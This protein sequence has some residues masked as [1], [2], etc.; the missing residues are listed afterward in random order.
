[1]STDMA[2][3]G[4]RYF[5]YVLELWVLVYIVWRGQ[6]RRLIGPW[7][8]VCLLFSVSVIRTWVLSICGL[9]SSEYYHAYWWTDLSLTLAAFL[10]VCSFFRRA[11]IHQER[12]WAILRLGLVFLFLLLGGV[13]ALWASVHCTRLFPFFIIEFSDNLYFTCL[14]LNTLLYVLLQQIDSVDDELQ[15]LV[16]GLGIQ[17][18]GPAA[19]LA[20]LHLAAGGHFAQSLNSLA[21]PLCTVGMLLTWSYAITLRWGLLDR[22]RRGHVAPYALQSNHAHSDSKA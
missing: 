4:L 2:S 8:Y 11:C 22:P 16:C 19:T 20:L 14:V 7:L 18:A 12:M 15:L 10:L 13:S 5:G 17:F 1:M 6:L 21:L 3:Y 9:E